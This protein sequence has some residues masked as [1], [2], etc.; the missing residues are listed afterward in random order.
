MQGLGR[1]CGVVVALAVGASAAWSLPEDIVPRGDVSYDLLASLSAA[2]RLKNASVADFFRGDRLY[3]RRE[4]AE[5]V[6]DMLA[7]GD[8]AAMPSGTRSQIRALV[9]EFAPELRA[10]G[11]VVPVIPAGDAGFSALLK[12]RGGASPVS[13][14]AIARVSVTSAVGRD[15]VAAL[16]FGNYRDEWYALQPNRGEF[17]PVET[18]YI[19]L[20]T[21]AVDITVGRQPLRWSPGFSGALILSDESAS[22]PQI[23]FEK[24]FSLPGTVGRRVG[25]LYYTQFAGQEFENAVPNADP[26]A[27]GTRRYVFGR[28]LETAG[29]RGAW[30]ASLSETFKSTRLP[31]AFWGFALPFYAYQNA[32]TDEPNRD[33][34][35]PFGFVT[36]GKTYPNT[37][38]FNYM[39]DAQ[40]TYRAIP[41]RDATVYTDFLIDDINAPRGL[42]GNATPTP[43]K[44][45]LLV[46][47][48]CPRID[49]AGR[50]GLRLEYATIDPDTYGSASPP[51]AYALDG[52]PL[53]YASGGNTHTY[54][55]RLDARLSDKAKVSA[56]A[57]VRR[58]RDANSPGTSGNRFSLYGSYNL[59]R[60]AFVGARIDSISGDIRLPNVS[61]RDETRGEVSFGIG[62]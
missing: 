26:V 30:K 37:A 41:D 2:G 9:V 1:V 31:G 22:L 36:G 27:T 52:T 19:R 53:G 14:D 48:Y 40:L 56:E 6:A 49:R 33:E 58:R 8:V 18:A 29:D 42:Q 3:T 32:F 51:V 54:F 47:G 43:R 60:A 7:V 23:R 39:V 5:F 55:G 62:F 50:F 25:R 28:R 24:G 4:M 59:N 13:G 45:G 21:R 61:T 10:R 38:W 35:R 12:V 20:N 16:S 11:V 15:A 46:G 44:I 34:S 17:P 57:N